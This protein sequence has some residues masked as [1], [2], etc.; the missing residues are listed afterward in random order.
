M[1]K[2]LLKCVTNPANLVT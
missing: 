1:D 2:T